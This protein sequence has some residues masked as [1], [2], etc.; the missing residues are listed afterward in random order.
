MQILGERVMDMEN[1]LEALVFKKSRTRIVE[2][3]KTGQEK[4]VSGSVTKCW[5]ENF[6]PIRKLPAS[7]L[8]LVKP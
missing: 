2:F 7:P 6:S 8:P 5:L 3:L 1:R 4:K